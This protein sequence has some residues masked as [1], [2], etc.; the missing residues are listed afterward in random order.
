M[1]IV[2]AVYYVKIDIFLLVLDEIIPLSIDSI[3]Y[4]IL[5]ILNDNAKKQKV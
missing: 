3:D 1:S 4:R 2:R 5:S